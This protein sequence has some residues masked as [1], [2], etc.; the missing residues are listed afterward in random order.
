[1]KSYFMKIVTVVV[2]LLLYGFGFSQ[3]GFLDPTFGDSGKVISATYNGGI[4][5]SLIQSDGKIIVGGTGTYLNGDKLL[6]GSLL[7]RYNSDGNLDFSFADSGRG[8]YILADTTSFI[9]TIYSIALQPDGKI[10]A[11]GQPAQKGSLIGFA[12]MRFNGDGTVDKSFGEDGI[13]ITKITASD[14]ARAMTLLPDGKILVTGDLHN[15]INDDNR[16]FITCYT[17]DGHLDEGFGNMGIVTI[18]LDRAMDINTI[19]TTADNKIIIGGQ[20]R[21]DFKNILMRFN[22]NGTPDISFGKNGLAEL[23]FDQSITS[24]TLKSIAVTSDQKIIAGGW[25]GLN[26]GKQA[27]TISRFTQDGFADSSF[28][29]NAYTVTEYE[30]GNSYCNSVAIQTN[31]K[32][33][34]GGYFSNSQTGILTLV[35]YS[36]DGLIDTSFGSGGIQNTSFYGDDVGT[37]LIIQKDGKIV[38]SGYSQID[39][40]SKFVVVLARY[41]GDVSRRQILIAKIRRWLQHHNG[42]VWDNIP[43][44]KSYAVQ[45]S[46]DG[47]RWTTI[48]TQQVTA[49]SQS[50]IINSQQPT[51]N[52]YN[53][54]SPSSGTNYYRLQTTSVSGAVVTSNIIAVANDALNVSLS[55]NP[56]KNTLLIAGLPAN[57]KVKLTVAD[58]SGNVKLQAL[59]NASSYN[60]NIASLHAGN[61]VIKMDIN[62]EL[63]SKQ[64]VKE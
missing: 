23:S 2:F 12:V 48:H 15:K 63:V 29:T 1:M 62:S 41:N 55:P 54:P 44:V 43:G 40:E 28:G 52:S 47:V 17:N 25:I 51:V 36:Q 33:V 56:A 64:F 20:Y 30:D 19:A 10:V 49:N 53:D 61:Y 21:I 58:F 42:I 39:S 18:V 50:Y 27:I 34:A 14:I 5:S 4:Y 16:S 6:G 3:D 46:A 8:V 9:P 37:S 38:L 60:L 26:S 45:R 22:N 7:A 32:I 11:L 57:E 24:G 13:T 35:R 31:G 59:A